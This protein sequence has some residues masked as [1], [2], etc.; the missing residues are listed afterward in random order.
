MFE[1]ID[2]LLAEDE[3]AELQ[4]Q[5]HII[6]QF[7]EALRPFDWTG[8]LFVATASELELLPLPIR[9]LF[10]VRFATLKILIPW[11]F[12]ANGIY[13]FRKSCRWSH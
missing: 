5:V 2:I 10:D 6:N 9:R 12:I 13:F 11:C 8:V 4:S 1:D 7:K 3:S